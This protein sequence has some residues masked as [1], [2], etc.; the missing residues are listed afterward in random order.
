MIGNDKVKAF[1]S[2]YLLIDVAYLRRQIFY[3]RLKIFYRSFLRFFKSFKSLYLTIC[4]QW[5]AFRYWF[6]TGEIMQEYLDLLES[7]RRE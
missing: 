1:E 5:I 3:L 2:K 4:C 6:L 7:Q